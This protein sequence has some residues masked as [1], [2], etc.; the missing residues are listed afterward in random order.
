MSVNVALGRDDTVDAGRAHLGRYYGFLPG[1]AA[2]NAADMIAGADDARDTVRACR[3][4]GF[5][6]L[7]FHPA[8][9]TIDQVDRLADAVL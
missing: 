1:F 9:A 6:R 3:D 8:V 2:L 4:M 7:L 5:D